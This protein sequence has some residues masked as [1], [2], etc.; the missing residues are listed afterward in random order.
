MVVIVKF[1]V[2]IPSFNPS[3][4]LITS[5]INQTLKDIEII[6]VNDGSENK[7]NRIFSELR[8]RMEC[9][10]LRHKENRG[11]GVAI[12]TALNYYFNNLSNPPTISEIFASLSASEPDS[13]EC[14][15]Q[16]AK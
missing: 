5:L 14:F 13:K 3:E 2:V 1:V 7:C 15:T 11:K 8:K 12:K 9:V 10:V 6:I 16:F 4:A